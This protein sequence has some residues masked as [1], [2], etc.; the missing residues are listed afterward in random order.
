MLA[1]LGTLKWRRE[2]ERER[3]R[4]GELTVTT[5]PPPV[6][7]S[8]R[9]SSP[10]VW[11]D[12]WWVATCQALFTTRHLSC[13]RYTLLN[14]RTILGSHHVHEIT[15]KDAPEPSSESWGKW[16]VR[17]LRNVC[18][19]NH[20]TCLH[21]CCLFVWLFICLFVPGVKS[22]DANVEAKTVV[23]E[24]D[25]PATPQAMLEKLQKVSTVVHKTTTT[26]KQ[27]QQTTTN[28]CLSFSVRF[29]FCLLSTSSFYSEKSSFLHSGVLPVVNR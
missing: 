8:L 1:W 4:K 9:D 10:R 5:K 20:Y 24:S 21:T 27:P 26:T 7:R 2:K 22:I 15:A 13:L 3:E 23:V 14:I 29:V 18:Q 19:Y 17:C 12:T 25:P 6:W 11:C 16:K 28:L